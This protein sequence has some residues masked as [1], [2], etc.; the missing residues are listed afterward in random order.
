MN[1]DGVEVKK[2]EFHRDKRGWL[3]ELYRQDELQSEYHPVM[4]Y[5]SLTRPGVAR[6]PHE[7]REQS[8]LFCFLGPSNFKLVLWDNRPTSP[9]YGQKQELLVGE[10]NPVS[11]LIPPGVVHAYKNVGSVDGLVINCA[12]RLYRGEGRNSPPDEIRH[13]DNPETIFKID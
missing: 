8:D 12:N 2:L 9:T 7:H 1:I 4:S 11:V 10:D 5:A 6:G 3:V 13:E